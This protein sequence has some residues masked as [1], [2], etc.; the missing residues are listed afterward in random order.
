MNSV[1]YNQ[2]G[3]KATLNDFIKRETARNIEIDNMKLAQ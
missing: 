2:F 3:A 1:E